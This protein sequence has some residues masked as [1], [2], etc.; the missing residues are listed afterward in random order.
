MVGLI[1]KQLTESLVTVRA[2]HL[3][4]EIGATTPSRGVLSQVKKYCCRWQWC[5]FKQSSYD[6]N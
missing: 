5:M 6:Q 2:L 3:C 4:I 1:V